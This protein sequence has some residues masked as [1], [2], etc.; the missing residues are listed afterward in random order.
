M[1][2]P[3]KIS[4]MQLQCNVGR[5]VFERSLI[6]LDKH[7]EGLNQLESTP[8]KERLLLWLSSW[9]HW[10]KSPRKTISGPAGY[11]LTAFQLQL[12]C[13]CVHGV[14]RQ[15][16]V[17][18]NSRCDSKKGKMG[19]K[20][21]IWGKGYIPFEG[22]LQEDFHLDS[23]SECVTWSLCSKHSW[24]FLCQ[25]TPLRCGQSWGPERRKLEC[26]H[27]RGKLATVLQK[28]ITHWLETLLHPVLK[29][30][31]HDKPTRS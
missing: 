12:A 18:R 11:I 13:L 2:L 26:G 29:F 8:R 24:G 6:S 21:V 30:N 25:V 16:H 14:F 17:T 10:S 28:R 3:Q 23:Y 31:L 4:H 15:V 22:P 5:V 7:S 1:V 27:W 9:T 20:G 19:S